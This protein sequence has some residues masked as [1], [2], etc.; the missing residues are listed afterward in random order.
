MTLMTFQPAP[1]KTVS[2]SWMI[3]PLPR[4]GPSRR[5]RLQLTTKMR[6]SSFSREAAA[7]QVLQEA[8]LVDRHDRAEPHR[9][10]R[11]LPEV[12]HQPGV[13]V[14]R[15]PL[16]VEAPL[17]VELLAEALELLVG[18]PALEVGARVDTRRGVA[19]DEDEVAAVRVGGRVPEV[20]EAD[21]VQ[22]GRRLVARDVAA[23]LR[24]L[25]VG[26]HDHRDRV[27]ADRRADAVLELE[28]AGERRLELR[29]DRVDVRGRAL[30]GRWRAD[31]A[32]AIDDALDELLRALDAVVGDDRVERVEPLAGLLGVYVCGVH[33]L[34]RW[35]CDRSTI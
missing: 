24:G 5:C 4:T 12:R 20:V 11:E 13:R 19:L 35:G 29:R 1:R 21:L 14:R 34:L 28:V 27:P 6:L 3:L 25:L 16:A 31:A 33:R 22:R 8:G 26:L 18:Q 7:L 2:S 23:E 9:H 17:L 10:G 30:V 32:G 15:Q